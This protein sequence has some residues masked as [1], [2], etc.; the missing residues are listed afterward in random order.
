L[1]A[2]ESIRL[3]AT[4]AMF[5]HGAV[6]LDQVLA[7]HE[8]RNVD[9]AEFEG[10]AYLDK[11]PGLSLLALP[12]YGALR[13]FS[14]PADRSTAHLWL[15]LLT[16]L[17]VGLPCAAAMIAVRRAT[18]RLGS[19]NLAATVAALA[20]GLASPYLVYATL[21]FGHGLAAA[22]V[23]FAITGV[24]YTPAESGVRAAATPSAPSISGSASSNG[25]RRAGFSALVVGAAVG[26]MV[27]VE[28]QTGIL[29][30]G[31]LAWLTARSGPRALALA[32]AGA[33]PF[34]LAQAAWN[35][36]CFDD[37]LSFGY[38]HKAT[39]EFRAILGDGVFGI[40]LPTSEALVGLTLG[41]KRGLFASAPALV[42]AFAG[43]RAARPPLLIAAAYVLVLSGFGDWQAGDSYGP[44]HLVP[45]I[46]LFGVALGLGV[47]RLTHPASRTALAFLLGVGLASSYLPIATFPYA[48]VAFDAPLIQLAVPLALDGHFLP[49]A[50]PFGLVAVALLAGLALLV[51]QPSWTT[52]GLVFVALAATAGTL[53]PFALAP[54][55][56][57]SAET[58][59]TRALVECLVGYGACE[60]GS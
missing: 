25:P 23:S 47:D 3:F 27:L 30:L 43:G 32:L 7:E 39:A 35:F 18:L 12:L 22:L 29:A 31:L 24:V 4:Q 58:E 41:L 14:A 49:F 28:T 34:A 54:S 56:S 51:S 38:A 6:E 53:V 1:T 40:G 26:L 10:H 5:D 16:R 20:V 37:P 44:R 60:P 52:R 11:A 15:E 13:T 21:F 2:N 19:S 59:S 8:A 57:T 55:A 17:L 48:P 33:T 36:A 42:F 45:A 50:G 9:R 46:P